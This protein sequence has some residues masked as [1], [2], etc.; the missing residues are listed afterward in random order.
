MIYKKLDL[1]DPGFRIKVEL[2]LAENPEIF[3]TE[4]WR[5]YS[6]QLQLYSQGRW[7][8]GRVVTWTLKSTHQLGLA[9]DVAFL[10]KNLYPADWARWRKIADSAKKFGIDWGFDLWKKDKPHFQ[11]DGSKLNS[12]FM[13]LPDWG[14]GEPQKTVDEMKAAGITTD[15]KK[16]AGE[17]PLYQLFLMFKKYISFLK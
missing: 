8:D 6:R 17:I 15:P 14:N 13:T 7:T 10:G 5:S 11:D 9:V 12:I 3:A 16:T 2:F 1:L 4:T